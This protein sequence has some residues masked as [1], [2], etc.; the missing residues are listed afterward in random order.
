M[1]HIV[2][3]SHPRRSNALFPVVRSP[4]TSLEQEIDSLFAAALNGHGAEGRQGIPVNVREDNDNL[5]ISAEL[6]GVARHDIKVELTADEL[7]LTA[8]RK[9]GEQ[10]VSFA[11]RLPLPYPM[12]A[13][14]VS[15]TYENG[16]L[17]LV[18][19]KAEAVKPRKIAI[20]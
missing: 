10:A 15:A 6:P 20:N 16:I 5:H 12:Q 8:S 2:R 17:R 13:D 7:S 9:D 3:Y 14:K 1:Y 18:L 19:P 11:R 4:W